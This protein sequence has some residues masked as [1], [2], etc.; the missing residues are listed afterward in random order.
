MRW[1]NP[2]AGGPEGKA[3]LQTKSCTV[4]RLVVQGS[5]GCWHAHGGARKEREEGEGI[6]VMK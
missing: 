5:V 3:S 4:G 6:G 1:V 2:G